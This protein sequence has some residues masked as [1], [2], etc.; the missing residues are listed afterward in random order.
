MSKNFRECVAKS[1]IVRIQHRDAYV[2]ELEHKLK[3]YKEY[4]D[5]VD[6]HG[7]TSSYFCP[8]PECKCYHIY[9]GRSGRVKTNCPHI[10]QCVDCWTICECHD[11]T[12]AK[13]GGDHY[14]IKCN[15]QY[16]ER[17]IPSDKEVDADI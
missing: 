10:Q 5:I 7:D 6:P 12:G 11:N 2:A 14:C 8:Y 9:N 15:I 16:L 4:T 17:E 1:L 13:H 3:I